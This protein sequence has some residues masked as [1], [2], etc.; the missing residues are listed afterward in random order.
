MRPDHTNIADQRRPDVALLLVWMVLNALFLLPVLLTDHLPMQ[1]VP[2]HLA[3]IKTLADRHT[4]PSWSE[5][6]ESRLGLRPYVAYYAAGTFLAERVGADVANRIL[7]GLYVAAF[8][9]SCLCLAAAI[10]RGRCWAALFA[11]LLV[12]SDAYLVGFVNYLLSL[13]MVLFAAALA[14][15]F[16]RKD[17]AGIPAATGLGALA[18]LIHL[19]HPFGV[20]VLVGLIVALLPFVAS[21]LRRCLWIGA[22]LVPALT[23][24]VVSAGQRPPA[25]GVLRLPFAFKLE[26]LLRTPFM[27]L[28]FPD[29]SV[30]FAATGLTVVLIGLV[31]RRAVQSGR[32]S[33]QA[34][35]AAPAARRPICALAL[36]LFTIAYAAA[37]FAVAS[38]VWLDLRLAPIVWILVFLGAGGWP[39][40]CRLGKGISVLLCLV[41]WAGVARVHR[42][43]SREIA[44]LF[45][46]LADMEPDR[47][48]LP[49]AWD[50]ESSA[51]NPFYVRDE[52]IPCFTPYAHFGSYYHLTKG[53]RSPWMTFHADLEWIPLRLNDPYYQ[54]AFDIAD[55]FLPHL[56]MEGLPDRA[57]HFDYLLIR[58]AGPD[59]REWIERVAVLKARAGPF[60]AYEFD[61]GS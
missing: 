43:F 6:F 46:V 33:H 4:D 24:L 38:T 7:L 35:R 2:N 57:A 47:R 23:A 11:F 9:L 10:D 34:Q 52:I 49:I 17:S 5:H 25:Q 31:L 58:G 55:P 42:D 41:S 13:P 37:P 14:V 48:V 27:L 12:Y 26:Y 20:L 28:D 51:V 39:T 18:I 56:I 32:W 1:D 59:V 60:A 15:R 21:G 19:T 54:A 3:I 36:A 40:A 30:F 53:G 50:P 8:P 22:A 45:S 29:E 44:P 61:L 16:V